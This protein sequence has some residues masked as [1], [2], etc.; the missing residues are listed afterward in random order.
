MAAELPM[1]AGP[2]RK[3]FYI[4]KTKE[5]IES[6]FIDVI[7]VYFFS[8]YIAQ[9]TQIFALEIGSKSSLLCQSN[10]SKYIYIFCCQLNRIEK[11]A[12]SVESFF[13][14]LFLLSIC[15]AFCMLCEWTQ[16]ASDVGD[17]L[18]KYW[19]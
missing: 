14:C 10:D 1:R 8:A 11:Q 3:L 5:E 13:F 4:G 7:T 12:H 2:M 19:F 16:I 6:V 17:H 18:E 9:R 15:T